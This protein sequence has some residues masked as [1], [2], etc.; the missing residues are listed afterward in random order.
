MDAGAI[1]DEV[2]RTSLLSRR[3]LARR[4]GTS[5][6]T[7]AAYES[8]RVV[9][10]VAVLA[11][12]IKAAGMTPRLT[13]SRPGWDDDE[14]GEELEALLDLADAFEWSDRGP[15]RFPILA[16]VVAPR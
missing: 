11:R 2:R 1:L 7:L 4:A 6:A 12:I 8:G 15:L 10:S 9:P 14:R 5:A 3:E 13:L 16:D